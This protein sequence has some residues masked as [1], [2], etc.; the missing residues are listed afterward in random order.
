MLTL[1]P[2]PQLT[3]EKSA[4]EMFVHSGLHFAVV[5]VRK[6]QESV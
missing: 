6:V 4:S 3:Q 5:H 2:P 1:S